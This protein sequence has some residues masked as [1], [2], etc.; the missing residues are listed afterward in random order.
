MSNL[1]LRNQMNKKK[2]KF[3]RQDKHKKKRIKSN[4]RRPRG[5]DS[6]V[7]LQLKGYIVGPK[8]GYKAPA[9][10]RGLSKAGLIEV[11]INNVQDLKQL[12]EKS[13]GVV[14]ATVGMKKKLAIIEEATKINVKLA[15]ADDSTV[16]KIEEIMKNKKTVKDDRKKKQAEKEKASKELKKEVKEAAK[17]KKADE[18]SDAEKKKERD[19]EL[20]KKDA[21]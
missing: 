19:K 3:I 13:I 2:P 14:A 21:I 6:K 11:K 1:D 5:I 8:V 7:R 20:I 18:K 10:V 17:E 4:W 16:K 15:N 12:D 9:D